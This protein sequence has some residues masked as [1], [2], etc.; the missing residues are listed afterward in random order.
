MIAFQGAGD[1]LLSCEHK[2]DQ[3]SVR[4]KG[5]STSM[6]LRR[7]SSPP[8]TIHATSSMKLLIALDESPGPALP[9]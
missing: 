5:V 8:Q 4:N 7:V 3:P 6:P 9:A 1:N 2:F